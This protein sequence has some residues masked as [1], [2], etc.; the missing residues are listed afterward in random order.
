MVA[1]IPDTHGC[2]CPVA[3]GA[4]PCATVEHVVGG[5]GS[6]GPTWMGAITDV[7]GGRWWLP[8]TTPSANQ[9]PSAIGTNSVPVPCQFTSMF[10]CPI[11]LAP[12]PIYPQAADPSWNTCPDESVLPPEKLKVSPVLQ[13]WTHTCSP[14]ADAQIGVCA[15]WRDGAAPRD[16][17]AAMRVLAVHTNAT[18][19]RAGHFMA[20]VGGMGMSRLYRR[21]C[22]EIGSERETSVDEVVD[23]P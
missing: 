20:D 12:S 11:G 8:F 3:N 4:V 16:G 19:E 14:S 15:V 10:P 17:P 7:P 5:G 2:G 23:V 22:Q 6:L 1:E 18:S 13:P 9:S 21:S